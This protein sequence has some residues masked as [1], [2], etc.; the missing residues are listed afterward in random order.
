MEEIKKAIAE[1]LEIVKECPSN[2]QQTCFEILLNYKLRAEPTIPPTESMTA[3]RFDE[4]PDPIEQA[5]KLQRDISEAD[6]HVKVRRFLEK[7][8][9]SVDDV[10]LLF[11]REN[12]QI[13][14]L[15]DDLKT[16]RTSESQIRIALMQ[17]LGN[18]LRTG[19][20]YT[21][22]EDVRSEATDRKCYDRNNFAG[23][24]TNNSGLFDYEK[25]SKS[26]KKITLSEQGKAELAKV[27]KELE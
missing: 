4:T 10:N 24:F 27:V 16:T 21:M 6:L 13:Y 23:N 15:F 25:Y 18:A 22:V 1:I 26:L 11:Y 20:F 17:C 3:N 2:L 12:D 8:A 14:P 19:E 5:E 9:L 7:Q